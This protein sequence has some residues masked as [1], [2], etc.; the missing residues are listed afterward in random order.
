MKIL[1]P[2][3][4]AFLASGISHAEEQDIEH[5][6]LAE[7]IANYGSAIE[8]CEAKASSRELP[9][10]EVMDKLT[11]LE[12][13]TARHFLVTSSAMAQRACE[14]PE[15]TELAYAIGRLE[16]VNLSDKASAVLEN[17]R[18][19][20]FGPG[21]WELERKYIELPESIKTDLMAT[22]YFD[23]PF[24]DIGILESLNR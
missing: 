10:P 8:R 3:F 17:T 18:P 7:K 1:I 12:P 23:E 20:L 13:D 15:L 24:D 16:E 9:S 21:S 22:G 11:S 14:K 6:Y 19:L 5:R 4:F 2:A